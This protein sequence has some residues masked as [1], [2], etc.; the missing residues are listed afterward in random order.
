MPRILLIIELEATVPRR[1]VGLINETGW[2]E[3]KIGRI[4]LF[5]PSG[6]STLF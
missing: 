4:L 6:L 3:Q 1:D 2:P 5:Y